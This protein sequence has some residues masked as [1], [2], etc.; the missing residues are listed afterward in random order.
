MK[1]HQ[2]RVPGDPPKTSQKLQKN[3][4]KNDASKES[5]KMQKSVK[6]GKLVEGVQAPGRGR[7]RVNPSQKNYFII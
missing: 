2:K 6:T 3:I 1:N 7:G 4:P 5:A